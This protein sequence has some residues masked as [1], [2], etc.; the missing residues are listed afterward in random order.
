MKRLILLLTGIML[1]FS[2]KAQEGESPVS[3][4]SLAI[5][6]STLSSNGDAS[7]A[8]TTSVSSFNG[9]GSFL[10]NPASMALSKM[11]FYSIGWFNQNNNQSN[12]YVGI[13]NETEFSNTS[14]GNL[15]LVYKV[16]T[17]RGSF[18]VG[19]GYNL[20][21]NDTDETFLDAFNESNSITDFFKQSGSDYNGIAFEAFAVDFRNDM[22]NEIESIFRVD[23]RPS[24]FEGISQFAEITRKRNIGEISLFAATEFQKNVF[25]GISLG[26]LSGSI[27]YDRSFQEVDESNVYNDGVIPASGSDPATDIFSIT[28]NDEIDTDF[29]GFSARGGVIFKPTPFL[30]LG[31][32][33][34]AP[35]K[36]FVTENFYS[37]IRTEFDDNTFID[38]DETTFTGEFEYGVTKPAEFKVGASIERMSNL[39][40]SAS[41]EYIDYSSTKVDFTVNTESLEPSDVAILKE[42]E[43]ATN[44]VIR[45]TYN[46]VINF[47]ANV[48][49]SFDNN[50]KLV[51]GYALF[52][53]KEDTYGFDENVY[54]G[55]LSFPIA[56]NISLDFSGQYSTRNDRSI[57][58]EFEDTVQ[59][60]SKEKQRLNIIAGVKFR[61]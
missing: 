22:S 15:G 12:N 45:N 8:A 36:I 24:G 60:I 6:M 17:D 29:Y 1:S 47:K 30:N 42:D 51:A 13:Q 38:G 9:Y 61:F 37:N 44:Q 55:G 23:G 14:F 5:Q 21:S 16:P 31:A 50:V 59:S 27:H 4:K 57:V 40:L 53:G 19:G 35:T 18:V 11:S 26:I 39:T 34:A 7:S 48:G 43:E 54:S 33:F 2:V 52:P 46:A 32:S 28:L 10:D 58:Y 3:Y 49:Y 20:I 25:A 41:L 56:E